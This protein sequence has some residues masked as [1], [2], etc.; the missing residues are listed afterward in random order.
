[1]ALVNLISREWDSSDF[2]GTVGTPGVYWGLHGHCGDLAR[3]AV[4]GWA[5]QQSPLLKAQRWVTSEK[6]LCCPVLQSPHCDPV[7]WGLVTFIY[8]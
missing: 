4:S 8:Q 1:M 2:L 7:A 5:G 6:T 3:N